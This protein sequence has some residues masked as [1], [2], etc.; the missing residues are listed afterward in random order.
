M[1]DPLQDR[2]DVTVG[3][4]TFT[5]RMPT[6][7]YDIEVG[8]KA[9]DVRRRASPDDMGALG[10]L[11]WGTVQFSRHCAVMELYLL[12][13]TTLWPYGFATDDLSQVDFDKAPKVDFEK[14][15]AECA[16]EV[17]RVGVAFET[18]MARFRARRNSDQTPAGAQ[19]VAGIGDPGA[20]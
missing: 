3:R 10:A 16:D 7:R 6:I 4:D 13:S 9:A 17:T 12:R 2:F 14:F 18:E 20:P 8:Y 1:P 15:P 19:A 5:F 11:D